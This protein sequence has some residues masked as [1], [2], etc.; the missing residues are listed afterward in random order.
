MATVIP[1]SIKTRLLG[2]VG[3]SDYVLYGSTYFGLGANIFKKD[4]RFI[5]DAVYRLLFTKMKGAVTLPKDLDNVSVT[6]IAVFGNIHNGLC[7]IITEPRTVSLTDVTYPKLL[8]VLNGLFSTDIDIG[9]SLP[10]DQ[11]EIAESDRL[12]AGVYFVHINPPAN[13][14]RRTLAY[15]NYVSDA[16][17]AATAEAG[18]GS[19]YGATDWSSNWL[20]AGEIRRKW[21][22]PRRLQGN[23]SADSVPKCTDGISFSPLFTQTWSGIEGFSKNQY[24]MS[25]IPSEMFAWP[26]SSLYRFYSVSSWVDNVPDCRKNYIGFGHLMPLII[27]YP[28]ESSGFAS[29]SIGDLSS[30]TTTYSYMSVYSRPYSDD[31]DGSGVY[32]RMT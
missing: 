26:C 31:S 2:R 5:R 9:D 8:E 21:N 28:L 4:G 32:H 19:L 17:T 10:P 3:Q 29:L 14:V 6:R 30:Y 27:T 20:V 24:S 22:W 23:L 1:S 25:W 15:M 12:A 11:I 16:N 7:A 18:T 13:T